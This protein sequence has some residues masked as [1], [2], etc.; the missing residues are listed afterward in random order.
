MQRL[1]AELTFY[2]PEM[3]DSG[4]KPLP[5]LWYQILT[6]DPDVRCQC[7]KVVPKISHQNVECGTGKLVHC[8]IV[9]DRPDLADQ[10]PGM[11]VLLIQ[12]RE[13]LLQ[14]VTVQIGRRSCPVGQLRLE[15][16]F[17]ETAPA[18]LPVDQ[19]IDVPDSRFQPGDL[20]TVLIMNP[21]QA[22]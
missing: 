9:A 17:L 14:L 22:A 16:L 6:F 18:G 15:A 19:L 7:I 21:L 1:S 2:C 13:R 4:V 3:N 5:D 12:H 8:Q 10:V 20:I 11:P